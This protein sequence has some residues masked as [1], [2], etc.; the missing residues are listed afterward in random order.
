MGPAIS[1]AAAAIG[2]IARVVLGN[3]HADHRGG[4][5]ALHAPGVCHER[6]RADVEGDG[7]VHY[8]DLAQLGFLPARFL[9]PRIMAS[10]NC[11]PLQVAG[12]LAEGDEVA[13]F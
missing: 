11:G 1:A 10:W 9:V 3:A 7:G 4:A 12:T 5:A 8:F 2:P 6:G 13:G